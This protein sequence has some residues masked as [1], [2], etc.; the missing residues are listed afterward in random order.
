MFAGEGTPGADQPAFSLPVAGAGCRKAVDGFRFGDAVRR[1]SA[2]ASR[3]LRQGRQ[4]RR[5]DRDGRR[6]EEAVLGLRSVR[7]EHVG[8]DDDQRAGADDSRIFHEHGDRPAGRET[9]SR[10]RWLGGGPRRRST[11]TSRTRNG[12]AIAAT[13]RKATM[14]SVSA[15]SASPANRSS[16]PTTYARIRKGHDGVGARHGAGGYSQRRPGTEHLYFLDRV[17]DEDDGRRAAV[18]HRQ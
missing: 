11:P 6:H 17:R 2:R 3:H 7:V 10:D 14:V 16:M 18:L 4:L 9:P 8:V 13:C 15:C 5:F 1:G 12:R